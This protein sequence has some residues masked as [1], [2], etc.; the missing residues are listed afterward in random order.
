MPYFVKSPGPVVLW[1]GPFETTEDATR[2]CDELKQDPMYRDQTIFVIEEQAEAERE[3]VPRPL[4]RRTK[5]KPARAQG[6]T[7][8]RS[9]AG[10]G[11]TALKKSKRRSR[12]NQR[13]KK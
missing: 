12:R 1:R 13:R 7:S 10:G 5:P 6:R 4:K 3:G 9:S 2:K 11:S 8:S